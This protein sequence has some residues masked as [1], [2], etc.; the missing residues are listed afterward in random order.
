MAE[1]EEE[2]F[3]NIEGVHFLYAYHPYYGGNN[4]MYTKDTSVCQQFS[5]A[6]FFQIKQDKWRFSLR[7]RIVEDMVNYIKYQKTQSDDEIVIVMI[8]SSTAGK[9]NCRQLD[10]IADVNKTCDLSSDYVKSLRR[11]KS[12]P[13][14][15]GG[16]RRSIE[17]H[18]NSMTSTNDFT[19][20]TVV[21]YDDVTTSGSS[22]EAGRS[23]LMN[24][25]LH[26]E[27]IMFFALC[28]TCDCTTDHTVPD[29]CFE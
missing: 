24:L 17:D 27:R 26:P 5:K 28:K 15:H 22:L 8:P 7:E 29:E 12:I 6:F 21:L 25:E 11:V 13:S 9:I 1:E 14:A 18:T 2:L 19:G 10:I 4:P 20:K 3:C 23:V 16:G